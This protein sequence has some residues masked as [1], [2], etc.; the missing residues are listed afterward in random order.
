MKFRIPWINSKYLRRKAAGISD[1]DVA[2]VVDKAKKIRGKFEHAGPL[3]KYLQDVELLISLVKDYWTGEYRTIPWWALSAIVFALL[4]VISPIDLIP[5][6]IPVIGY[7]D[8]AAVVSVCLKLVE[9]ELHTYKA[10]KESRS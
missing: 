9:Q 3:G 1:E 10:W 6:F 4:Y 8:D 5:D 2:N 7:L